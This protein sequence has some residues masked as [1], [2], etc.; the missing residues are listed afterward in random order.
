MIPAS[1][2]LTIFPVIGIFA[3][4]ILPIAADVEQVLLIEM[5]MPAVTTA[6][7]ILALYNADENHGVMHTLVT[8]LTVLISLRLIVLLGGMLL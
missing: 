2:K 7:V 1:L 8:N 3:L 5:A 6:S 4:T